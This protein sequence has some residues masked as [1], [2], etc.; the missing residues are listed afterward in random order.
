MLGIRKQACGSGKWVRV[1][2]E[3]AVAQAPAEA[4]SY[5]LVCDS[6]QTEQRC[7]EFKSTADA[8]QIAAMKALCGTTAQPPRCPDQGATGRCEQ[9]G[10]ITVYYA[11][12][13]DALPTFRQ[14]CEQ[15]GGSWTKP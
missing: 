6:H 15:G 7:M 14:L 8:G 9:K 1:G 12:G 10:I 5:A 11:V 13:A 4:G 2:G 3:P